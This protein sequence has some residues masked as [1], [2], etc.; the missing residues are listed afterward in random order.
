MH[1]TKDITTGATC[2]SGETVAPNAMY[3]D[4]LML[5]NNYYGTPAYEALVPSNVNILQ[6]WL[7][8]SVGGN[9]RSKICDYFA[10]ALPYDYPG[11]RYYDQ[12]QI[13]SKHGSG[14]D[15]VIGV[16]LMHD[17]VTASWGIIGTPAQVVYT[18]NP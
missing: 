6:T 12:K 11:G 7:T 9:T 4:Y 14:V 5:N 2:T 18:Q 1:A 3:Y 10:N 16:Y 8:Q 15:A 13:Y 17:N